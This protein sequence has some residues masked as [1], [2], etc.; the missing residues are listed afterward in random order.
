MTPLRDLVLDVIVNEDGDQLRD[1]NEATLI[2]CAWHADEER[3]G[4]RAYHTDYPDSKRIYCVLLELKRKDY[5]QR[6]GP[7]RWKLTERGRLH[8]KAIRNRVPTVGGQT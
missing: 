8:L 1:R 5:I 3:L 4:M 6:S 2:C 7:C